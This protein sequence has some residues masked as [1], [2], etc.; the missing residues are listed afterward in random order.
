MSGGLGE[1]F[2]EAVAE[3]LAVDNTVGEAEPSGDNPESGITEVVDSDVSDLT[4][5]VDDV[6]VDPAGSGE[7]TPTFDWQ[8]YADQL[9]PT[10]VNGVETA[11]PLSELRS[12]Y[13]RQQDYTQKT[14]KVAEIESAAQWGQDV[15]A[16]LQAD[17]VGTLTAFMRA[18]N[19]RPDAFTP[20][21]PVQTEAWEGLD[22]EFEPVVNELK[23]AREELAYLRNQV[24]TLT[25]NHVLNEVKAEIGQ[26]KA[27]FGDAFDPRETL[28]LAAQRN[29]PL[30]DAHMLR[31]AYLQSQQAQV[32]Q[33]VDQTASN[34]AAAQ[35]A[36]AEA[37]RQAAKRK[38]TAAGKGSFRA[39]EVPADDFSD[40]GELFAIVANGTN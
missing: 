3:S 4:E 5:N 10:V 26:L 31:T 2:D 18:F 22:P 15:Q 37:A 34:A 39:S 11:V 29:L 6:E 7:I 38:V 33:V 30:R 17:P 12:G 16:A 36:E 21:Q 14:Q 20:A 27:E 32:S 8:Q 25:G 13:M 1:L 23:S 28:Q 35:A 24:E 19:I 9:V 40:I